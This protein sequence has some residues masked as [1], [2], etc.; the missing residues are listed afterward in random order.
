MHG[1]AHVIEHANT[2]YRLLLSKNIAKHSDN[3]NNKIHTLYNLFDLNNVLY[4]IKT[5]ND[6]RDTV[7]Y[8]HA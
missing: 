6:R 8:Y 1:C 3:F 5:K 7:A 4:T 2:K